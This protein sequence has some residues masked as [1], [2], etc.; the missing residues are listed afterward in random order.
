MR[1]EK[2]RRDAEI[3]LSTLSGQPALPHLGRILRIAR[4]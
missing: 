1:Q 2:G 3:V 4:F